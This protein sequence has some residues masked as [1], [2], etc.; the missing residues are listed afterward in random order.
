MGGA[1][2]ACDA[3]KMEEATR[4]MSHDGSPSLKQPP[5]ISFTT[6]VDSIREG[7]RKISGCED[8]D[9][10]GI[11]QPDLPRRKTPVINR[12]SLD[13]LQEHDQFYDKKRHCKSRSKKH[14]SFEKYL[15]N[16][17][18]IDTVKRTVKWVFSVEPSYDK[19]ESLAGLPMR[20][21]ILP[22][23]YTESREGREHV[24]DTVTTVTGCES[25]RGTHSKGT[26]PTFDPSKP[27]LDEL[28]QQL[29]QKQERKARQEMIMLGQQH[30]LSFNLLDVYSHQVPGMPL[31]TTPDILAFMP[32]EVKA[33]AT[34][35]Q[36]IHNT[37]THSQHLNYCSKHTCQWMGC[38]QQFSTENELITHV[39]QAHIHAYGTADTRANL[40]CHW[41]QCN[42]IF[43][44][45]Y[46]LLIHVR[47]THC[48]QTLQQ[49]VIKVIAV[50]CALLIDKITIL[51]ATI[52]ARQ[53][54]SNLAGTLHYFYYE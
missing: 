49:S 43:L 20:G 12:P 9:K 19:R 24:D 46:K 23:R 11:I 42:R 14:Q 52:K 40:T 27:R 54:E 30:L 15:A 45:R 16:I 22:T 39:D 33:Q 28:F 6:C 41:K 4:Q 21:T 1:R 38:S 34:K 36:K 44:A 37:S 3:Q 25:A 17:P 35:K 26:P 47:N 51:D 50:V 29:Q 32:E 5:R 2:F 31:G 48:K 7:I 53:K 13:L 10:D 8:V 18:K